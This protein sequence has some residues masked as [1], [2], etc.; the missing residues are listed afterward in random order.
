LNIPRHVAV[1]PDGNRRWAARHRLPTFSGHE[2]GVD[3]L[4]DVLEASYDL[5]IKCFSVW[6]SSLANLMER[7]QKEVQFLESIYQKQFKRLAKE[8]RIH[9]EQVRVRVLG[10]WQ[11]V[12]GNGAQRSIRLAMKATENY[13]HLS[14]NFFIAYDGKIEMLSAI[15]KI[16]E[17]SR[18][19]QE[20][21]ITPEL[22]KQNLLTCDLPPVDLLIRTGGE[23][24]LSAAFMMWEIGESQL[25]FSDKYWPD[26][27]GDD[28]R[29]AIRDFQNRERRLAK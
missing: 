21:K 3:A 19:N 22:V 13:N 15:K 20:L 29:D 23:P 25:Y 18:Q 17:Q 8:K 12:L 6:G 11:T 9:E 10:E 4:Q 28:L 24:H 2:K 5:S 14:L 26:F 7:S 27:N 16:L 1:I